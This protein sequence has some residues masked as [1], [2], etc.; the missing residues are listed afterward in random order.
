MRDRE[1]G[2]R[3]LIGVLVGCV[4]SIR[5]R[6][7]SQLIGS[8]SEN[9]STSFVQGRTTLHD[10]AQAGDAKIIQDLLKSKKV[11]PNETDDLDC[12]ALH[13]AVIYEH[14]HCIKT[15]IQLSKNYTID[16]V[17]PN[18][19]TKEGGETSKLHGAYG[20]SAL[21]TAA[22]FGNHVAI[23]LLINQGAHPNDK[24]NGKQTALHLAAAR[25]KDSCIDPLIR[26]GATPNAK[27]FKQGWTPLHLAARS[28]RANCVEP[29]IKHGVTANERVAGSIFLDTV[30]RF[31]FFPYD[32]G[33]EPDFH[34]TVC[35]RFNIKHDVYAEC[36]IR[37]ERAVI[38]F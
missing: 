32:S 29:L 25:G 27:A 34:F 1:H 26:N 12:T 14:N 35:K 18:H 2:M 9:E 16:G 30:L 22:K 37:F 15:L 6:K 8:L 31:T 24:G 10:S 23:E 7:G 28:G 3:I 33:A 17:N 4:Y 38:I 20:C 13:L 36:I 5:Q 19:K 11:D 21:H